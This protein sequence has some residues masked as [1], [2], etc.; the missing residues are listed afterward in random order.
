VGETAALLQVD[1]LVTVGELAEAI[2]TGAAGAGLRPGKGVHCGDNDEA[3]KVLEKI[4]GAG[5]TVLVKGSRGMKMEQIVL[6]L[7]KSWA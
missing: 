6:R 7:V 4:L 2:H 5:D 1:Y 3:I